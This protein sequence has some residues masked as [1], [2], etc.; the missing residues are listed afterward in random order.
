[1]YSSCCDARFQTAYR[2]M[3]GG[4]VLRIPHKVQSWDFGLVETRRSCFVPP[5][6][7]GGFAYIDIVPSP[8]SCRELLPVTRPPCFMP[9][10]LII[11]ER[12][13]YNNMCPS[14]YCKWAEGKSPPTFSRSTTYRDVPTSLCL[15]GIMFFCLFLYKKACLQYLV[16]NKYINTSVLETYPFTIS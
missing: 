6:R 4:Q 2:R 15:S 5:T 10:M 9:C 11:S 8:G 1:M 13:T 12:R 14:F 7:A 3:R 16:Q